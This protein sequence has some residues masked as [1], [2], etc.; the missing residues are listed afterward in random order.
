LPVRISY[1]LTRLPADDTPP[2]AAMAAISMSPA[3]ARGHAHAV[4]P[5]DVMEPRS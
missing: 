2:K 4:R 1:D 3:R 5:S